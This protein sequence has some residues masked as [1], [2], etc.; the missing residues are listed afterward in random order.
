MARE[1]KVDS[2]E[3]GLELGL[4]ILRFFFKSDHLHYGLFTDELRPEIA[5]LK[6]AQENYTKLLKSQI[7]AGT[8]SILDV[9]CGSGATALSLIN[10]GYEVECVSPGNILTAQVRK[11]L[12]DKAIVHQKKF[13]EVS[14]DKKYDLILF[15]ESFQYIPMDNSIPGALKLLNPGG[16]IIVADFFKTDAPGKSPLGGGHK[17]KD[18]QEKLVTFPV[19]VAYERDITAETSVTMDIVHQFSNDVFAPVWKSVFELAEDR[20]PRTTK[21]L[22]WKFKKKLDKIENKHFTGQRNG[23]NFKKYKKYMLYLL[24]PE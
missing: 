9:G 22:K 12:G 24:K 5:D 6:Q 19:T 7:P 11:L 16:S 10:D 17:Y 8:K 18:W 15:S 2:K 23:A 20:A 1:K 14:I 4:V 21:F 3:V 13:E